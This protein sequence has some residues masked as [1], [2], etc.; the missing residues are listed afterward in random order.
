LFSQPDLTVY[1]LYIKTSLQSIFEEGI[2]VNKMELKLLIINKNLILLK[3]HY[4]NKYTNDIICKHNLED[5]GIKK[6]I[7][8]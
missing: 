5:I 3:T 7:D 1:E 4:G 8:S 6:Y 2:S